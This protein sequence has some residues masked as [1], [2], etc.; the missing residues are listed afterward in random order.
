MSDI[1]EHYRPWLSNMSDIPE[2]YRQWVKR[3]PDGKLTTTEASNELRALEAVRGTGACPEILLGRIRNGDEKK[4]EPD[5]VRTD[6]F[7]VILVGLELTQPAFETR[8]QAHAKLDKRLAGQPPPA[9]RRRMPSDDHA[10]Q[11]YEIVKGDESL[12]RLQ[13]CVENLSADELTQYII[14]CIEKKK[15]KPYYK[16]ATYPLHLIIHET[17]WHYVG[18]LEEAL[19][20]VSQHDC[21]KFA[22]VW[23]VDLDDNV[24]RLHPRD[25]LQT[26]VSKAVERRRARGRRDR[27]D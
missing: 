11:A 2:R 25:Q 3:T 21:G 15:Q 24:T 27:A 23:Y 5:R 9:H 14:H 26:F 8:K 19:A 6:E 22:A 12:Q 18:P 17:G 10:E 20:K 4:G 7:G 1:P 16:E 13:G